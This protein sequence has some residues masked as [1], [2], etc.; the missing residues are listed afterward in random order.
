MI[1]RSEGLWGPESKNKQ[2]KTKTETLKNK[3]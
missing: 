1:G 3:N 2:T